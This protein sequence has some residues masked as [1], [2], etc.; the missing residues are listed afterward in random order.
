[1]QITNVTAWIVESALAEPYTIAYEVVDRTANVFVRVET[2]RGVVGYGCA[3]PDLE[4][5][6]ETAD[7]TLEVLNGAVRDVLLRKDPLRLN[8]RLADVEP[9]LVGQPSA[10][11][12]VDMC[13]HD[14]LGKVANLPLWV[15]L[16]GFR[17]RIITA[18][19]VG[20][21]PEAETVERSKELR[22]LGFRALK[23][24]GGNDV[25]L[26]IARVLKVREA[27][28]SAVQLRFD[29]NQGYSVS[30]SLHFVEGTLTAGL[31]LIEQPTSRDHPE[32][33]GQVTQKASIPVMADESL[34]T[35]RDAF[36]IAR[37]ELA[38]MVNIKLMKV[39]GLAKARRVD[40]VA[41][42]AGIE[43]MVGCMDESALAI[44]AALH[45]SLSQENVIY[46]DL[47]GH[48]DLVDDPADGAVIFEDG[49]LRPHEG[50]GLGWSPAED[51]PR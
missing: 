47:D 42:A 29:A 21:L 9:L 24:K 36:R 33:L 39:G 1:M 4:V 23:L 32:R 44:A 41:R 35:L 17:R 50:S 28:G 10:L 48:F 31:D 7:K 2:N 25:E 40:T 16:G 37:G 5:T 20:I 22:R 49:Y 8:R 6:G 27:L 11:A 51:R 13:L 30:Q 26:D 18:A 45:F 12:A 14:I 43:S 19:T 34:L 38:D 46:A 15:L 3:T